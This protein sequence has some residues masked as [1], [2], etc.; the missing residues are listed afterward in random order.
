MWAFLP[1]RVFRPRELD[2]LPW[3]IVRDLSI[4][5]W[6]GALEDLGDPT[7]CR[8]WTC[9][10]RVTVHSFWNGVSVPEDLQMIHCPVHRD[11]SSVC[12]RRTYVLVGCFGP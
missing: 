3:Y 5:P 1:D 4:L 11:L 8:S 9:P 10:M 2:D 12:Y 6:K 7:V